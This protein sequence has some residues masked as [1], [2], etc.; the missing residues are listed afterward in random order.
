MKWN[1]FG[2]EEKNREATIICGAQIGGWIWHT[3]I[4]D[5]MWGMKEREETRMTPNRLV[6]KL[7]NLGNRERLVKWTAKLLDILILRC[8]RG[9]FELKYPASNWAIL[10]SGTLHELMAVC[11]NNHC[12]STRQLVFMQPLLLLTELS[13]TP[14]RVAETEAS[15]YPL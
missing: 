4:T 9:P 1:K 8:L 6:L 5:G 12:S 10:E 11:V 3:L 7:Q 14:T 2:I 13:S 15:A